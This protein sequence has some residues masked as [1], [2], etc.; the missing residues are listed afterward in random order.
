[1]K[2]L[3]RH[4]LT[5]DFASHSHHVL[6]QL[7][8]L[9]R[10][11]D[12]QEGMLAFMERRPPQFYGPL[13]PMPAGAPDDRVAIRERAAALRPGRRRARPRR[14]WRRASPRARPTT[15][16]WPPAQPPTPWPPC[17]PRWHATGRRGTRSARSTPRST[18]T[19]PAAPPTAPRITGCP[20][21]GAAWFACGIAT[22]LERGPAGWRITAREV[23][24]ALDPGRGERR[25]LSA[26][27]RSS[28]ARA[29]ASAAACAVELARRGF[30]LVLTART[31]TGAERLEHSSTVRRTDTDPLPGSLAETARR[32]GGARRGARWSCQ[33]DLSAARATGRR[34]RGGARPLRPHRRAGQQRALRRPRPHGPVRG[35]ARSS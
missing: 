28:P 14:W 29:A 19:R 27:S 6:M 10:S 26:R 16:R 34:G 17:R 15:A 9:F 18:A 33:L 25:C 2:R 11:N 21:A 24:H 35:H 22:D 4:G 1:M 32:G 13:T 20:Q 3:Y 30:D 7:M 31:V 23:E 12:F 5:E 8:L